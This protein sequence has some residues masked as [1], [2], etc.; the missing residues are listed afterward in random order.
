MNSKV[1]SA[2][3]DMISPGTMKEE[4]FNNCRDTIVVEKHKADKLSEI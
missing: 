1:I 3:V 2:S 4:S